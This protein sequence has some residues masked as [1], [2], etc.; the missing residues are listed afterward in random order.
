MDRINMTVYVGG[1]PAGAADVVVCNV[2]ES[3][4][5]LLKKYNDMENR[6]DDPQAVW[7][8]VCLNAE[9]LCEYSIDSNNEL[10]VNA[11]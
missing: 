11:P 5:R 2:K 8:N 3:A 7:L 4:L 1:E 10:V 9:V 6:S